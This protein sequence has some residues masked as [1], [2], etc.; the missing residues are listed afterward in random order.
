MS[1][2]LKEVVMAI[3]VHC[4]LTKTQWKTW[5]ELKKKVYIV[6]ISESE[7]IQKGE[8]NLPYVHQHYYTLKD[9]KLLSKPRE[10][11]LKY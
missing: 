2:T 3:R 4:P 10:I 6:W 9:S 1:K 7:G 8:N 5:D 11:K